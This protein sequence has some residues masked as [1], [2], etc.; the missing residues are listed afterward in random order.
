MNSA[1]CFTFEN[2]QFDVQGTSSQY[3]KRKNYK[4]KF[5]NGFV[6]ANGTRA[7]AYAVSTG[8]IPTDTFCFKAD[9]A[10]SEGA[11]NVELARLYNDSC[12]YRTPAQVEDGR[13]RQGIDGFP[14]VIFWNN[15]TDTIFLGKY[16]FNYDKGTEEVFGFS[17]ED[18]SWEVLNN[19]SDRVLWKSDDYSGEDWLNDFEARFPDG[20][21]DPAQLAEFAAW[22]RGTDTAAVTG[23]FIEPV[24]IDGVEYTRDVEAYRLAKFRAGLPSLCEVDSAVFYYLF[25]ELFLMVDSRAKNMFPSFIGGNAQ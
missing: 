6:M 23:Q 18:E 9:V 2:A 7:G 21:T 10:S 16:N 11:N 20:C 22:I 13:I 12:P 8:G 5:K 3:Y 24:T 25:T 14:M 1:R 4:A 17:G 19:T 15:G